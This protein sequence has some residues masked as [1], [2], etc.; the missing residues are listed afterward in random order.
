MDYRMGQ[1]KEILFLVKRGF[2][3]SDILTMPV[4]IRRYYIQYI[5]E[6]ENQK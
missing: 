2:S 4:Y 1:L 5:V 3:Y 6:L